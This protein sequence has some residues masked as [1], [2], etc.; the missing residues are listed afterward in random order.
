MSCWFTSYSAPLSPPNRPGLGND[1]DDPEASVEEE[2]EDSEEAGTKS[3]ASEP[4]TNRAGSRG[5]AT[6]A[7]KPPTLGAIPAQ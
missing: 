6:P 7:M 4:G 3:G 5:A 2:A 1:P